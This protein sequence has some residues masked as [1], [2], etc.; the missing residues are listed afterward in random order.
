MILELEN[1]RL[2]FFKYMLSNPNILSSA[3]AST[4]NIPADELKTAITG[5]RDI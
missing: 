3:L 1:I 5:I 4:D 2:S